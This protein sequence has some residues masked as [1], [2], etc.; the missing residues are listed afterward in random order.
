MITPTN[1]RIMWYQPGNY[2]N[3][4]VQHDASKPLPAMVC[5]VWGD[6]MV[7]LDVVDSNGT[8]HARTS[9]P[10]VQDGS[11][12]TAGPSPYAQWMPYQVGQAAKHEA[13]KS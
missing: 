12:Y 4:I 10:I 1:G 5:H 13:A 6:H 7:N 11:P 2:L 9:V 3:G 8:H